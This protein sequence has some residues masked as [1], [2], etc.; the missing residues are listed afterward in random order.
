MQKLKRLVAIAAVAVT[1]F[2]T[3]SAGRG[4][5]TLPI[6]LAWE[7]PA[8]YVPDHYTIYANGI[9]LVDFGPETTSWTAHIAYV[10]SYDFTVTAWAGT[11]EDVH[12]HII[13]VVVEKVKGKLTVV[14]TY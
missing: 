1:A 5:A 4:P 6:P 11:F 2:F 10:G 12:V 7:A 14:A 8:T 3:I 9:P 13:G